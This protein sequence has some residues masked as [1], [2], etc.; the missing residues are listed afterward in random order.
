[1][2]FSAAGSFAVSGLLSGVGVVSLRRNVART[3]G[4]VAAIPFI[5]AVQQAAEGVVWLTIPR[6]SAAE[7]QRV[8]ATIFLGCA[9]VVWPVWL[10]FALRRVERV[11]DRRRFLGALCWAGVV[12]AVTASALLARRPPIV[13][14]AG[15]SIH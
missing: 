14:I 7:V 5:F 3:Y 8:A 1:M 6:P 15:H 11:P 2:C 12:V 9:L 13:A 10:S 4:L